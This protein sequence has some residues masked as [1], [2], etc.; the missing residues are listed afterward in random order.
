LR[1]LIWSGPA[2]R[3]LFAIAEH[4]RPIHPDLPAEMLRLIQS[5]PLILLDYPDIGAPTDRR[6]LRKWLVKGTPYLLFYSAN[7]DRVEIKRVRHG[8][9]D[10]RE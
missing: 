7:R 6:S 3:D 2:R 4:Y 5:A 8:A 1:P 10:W 9:Q